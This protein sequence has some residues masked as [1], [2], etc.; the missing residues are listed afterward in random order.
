MNEPTRIQNESGDYLEWRYAP[1][2]TA[3]IVDIKVLSERVKGKG[4]KLVETLVRELKSKQATQPVKLL[5]ALARADNEIARG[6]YTALGFVEISR[7]P[8]FYRDGRPAQ[9]AIVWGY[10]L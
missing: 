5:Y 10:S 9:D 4:R 7:L 1:G 2:Q 3:E 8:G 6:F